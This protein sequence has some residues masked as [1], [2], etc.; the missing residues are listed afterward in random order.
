M[1]VMFNWFIKLGPHNKLNFK[2]CI[3]C[4]YLI[5]LVEKIL[6][7]SYISLHIYWCYIS[8][9]VLKLLKKVLN[10]ENPRG[11]T[12]SHSL[13]EAGIRADCFGTGCQ[14]YPPVL[15][16]PWCLYKQHPHLRVVTLFTAD[17]TI[18][19]KR[20]RINCSNTPTFAL[21]WGF[22]GGGCGGRVKNLWARLFP[23]LFSKYARQ[24]SQPAADL[25]CWRAGNSSSRSVYFQAARRRQP[26]KEMQKRQ[27]QN[28]E[29]RR[30][31]AGCCLFCHLPSAVG[32]G[33]LDLTGATHAPPYLFVYLALQ[34]KTAVTQ[35]ESGGAHKIPLFSPPRVHFPLP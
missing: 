27:E 18:K 33:A 5:F 32:K 31:R 35:P 17:V 24:A 22:R 19:V 7:F 14:E 23:D 21:P 9:N 6:H 1:W 3:L 34:S 11:T 30:S 20:A 29:I 28:G 13:Q 26:A 25:C 8:F 4:L 12:Y 16:G 2:N 15:R 10:F